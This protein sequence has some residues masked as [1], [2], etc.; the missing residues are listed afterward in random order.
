MS[1]WTAIESVDAEEPIVV[2]LAD[3]GL[4]DGV[5]EFLR[6]EKQGAVDVRR[7]FGRETLA[8]YGQPGSYRWCT[9][10]TIHMVTEGHIFLAKE[11]LKDWAKL[12]A[13]LAGQP[14]K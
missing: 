4:L 1:C 2:E 8:C 14:I 10:D 9:V 11:L 12:Y 5:A 6:R 7:I 13:P 3:C